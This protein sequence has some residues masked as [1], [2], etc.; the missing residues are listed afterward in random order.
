MN[1]VVKTRHG[2][3]RGIVADGVF[4]FK[5]IPYAAPP[6][7]P[8]R[9]LPPQ[10]VEPWNGVR[11][12]ITY[13]PEAPQ[14]RPD[15][16][17][18]EL[19]PD[20]AVP[21]EDCLN[22]NIWSP[23][24]GTAGLPV[25]MW[26]PGGM[27]E[28]GSG[29]SYN[30][31]HFARDGIVCVTINYRVGVDGFLYL[32]DGNAN[33]GLLDQVAALE[34]VR[35]NIAAF[36]GD[37]GNVTIFG[38]SAGAMSVG[39]LLSMPRADG[40]FRRAI[41]QS[42]AAH[43]VISAA[44]AQRV[45]RYLAEKLG[46]E[47]TRE[48]ITEVPINRL[49]AAQAE[50]KANLLAHPDPE[51][52]GFE[53]VA[54]TL[55]WQPVVDGKIIPARPIDRIVAGAGAGVD[56]LVGTNT[57]EWRLFLVA[58]GAINDVTHEALAAAVAAY[59]LP[60]EATLAVY[61]AA[62]PGAS[63]GDLLAA[64]QTDWWCRIPAIRLADAHAKRTSATYM[65]EFAWRSPQLNGLLGACHALEIA[66]VFDTLDKGFKPM[67]GPLLG[68]NPPQQLADNMH[69][70]WVEFA[71]NGDCGWPNYDLNRRATM[72]FD[73]TSVVVDNPRAVERELWEGVR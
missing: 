31:S 66:F 27:F 15:P 55:P 1:T 11:D 68:D 48:A 40:L 64:I 46:V 43:Q 20:P 70:A 3:V 37:P 41:A 45:G 21:G 65:Y 35:D 26:I 60:V 17:A 53:V 23:E 38:E 57:D 62:H 71:T 9:F 14:L 18:A 51:R 72:R 22:L 4:T 44:T 33:L 30:G 7:G 13:G 63:P 61:S 58:S 52:W 49:L 19:A 54:S 32:G 47:A 10:S 67:V 2:E 8:N 73:T 69:A 28:V 39:T 42:G 24:L 59:G 36:G 12:A 5:G 29:A 34:W 16:Q 56:I 6:F 25:M 50:L